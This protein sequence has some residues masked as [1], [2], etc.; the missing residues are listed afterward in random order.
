LRLGPINYLT[1]EEALGAM[2]ANDAVI[3]RPWDLWKSKLAKTRR[4]RS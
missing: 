2:R 3:D 1:E 4:R